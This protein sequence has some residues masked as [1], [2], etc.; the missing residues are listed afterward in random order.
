MLIGLLMLLGPAVIFIITLPFSGWLRSGLRKTYLIV[1][2]TVVFLGSGTSYYFAAYAGDQGGIAA[3][4]LQMAVI[5]TYLLL[6]VG[7]AGWNWLL[8]RRNEGAADS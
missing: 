3:Y 8:I 2:G 7:L 5:A 6:S 1:G 4:F